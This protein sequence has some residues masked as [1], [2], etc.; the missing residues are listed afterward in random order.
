M[1][2][3][4]QLKETITPE[5]IKKIVPGCKLDRIKELYPYILE[6]FI[7]AEIM[8]LPRIAAWLAQVSHESGSFKYNEEL[9]S[10][11]AYEKRKDLGNI[12]KGDGVT[13][14][15]RGFIQITGRSNYTQLSKALG[16]DFVSKPELASK[17]EY[18]ARAAA[19]YW[20]SRNLNKYADLNSQEGFDKITKLIN[21]GWNGREQR[22]KFYEKAK[23]VLG[24][25]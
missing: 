10:G 8:S 17:D 14:K 23:E 6:A 2:T 24:I 15:G 19:W 13:F 18:S 5:V 20:K 4:D 21:G 22:N 9:A 7:E 3:V 12:Y 1:L 25:N 16:I 11:E